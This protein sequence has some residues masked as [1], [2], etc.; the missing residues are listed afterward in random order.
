[1]TYVVEVERRTGKW[2]KTVALGT[3]Q[4]HLISERIV[5]IFLIKDYSVYNT[6][7]FIF[8][9]NIFFLLL[10]ISDFNQQ[11]CFSGMK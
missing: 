11:K 9:W 2:V 7:T 10:C 5:T 3:A 6:A 4:E 1:M 8:I